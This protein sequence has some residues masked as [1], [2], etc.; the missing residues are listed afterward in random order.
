MESLSEVGI[1]MADA[2]AERL[3]SHVVILVVGPVGSEKGEVCLRTYVC[4]STPLHHVLDDSQVFSP[5]HLH[6]KH[7]EPGPHLTT[8]DSQQWRLPLRG[9]AALPLVSDSGI[10]T[11]RSTYIYIQVDLSA[12][13]APGPR[14]TVQGS[15]C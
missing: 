14:W 12:K 8:R 1:P 6:F 3:G 4:F 13:S 10:L 5:T 2:L 15:R 11:E 7:P 9:T